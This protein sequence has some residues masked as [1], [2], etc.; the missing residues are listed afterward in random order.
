M[1]PPPGHDCVDNILYGVALRH[2]LL[3]P[4]ADLPTPAT[5]AR[6]CQKVNRMRHICKKPLDDAGIHAMTCPNW[7]ANVSAARRHPQL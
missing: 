4:D 1:P 3:L 6:E 5:A 7:R 2:R